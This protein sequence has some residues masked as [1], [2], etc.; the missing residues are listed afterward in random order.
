MLI[1]STKIVCPRIGSIPLPQSDVT[2]PSPI[3]P[4]RCRRTH[5]GGAQVPATSIL[6]TL[7]HSQSIDFSPLFGQ[8]Q[9]TTI[10]K[11]EKTVKDDNIVVR[12]SIPRQTQEH[13]SSGGSFKR[14]GHLV[15][16]FAI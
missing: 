11:F 1:P 3:P 14:K 6:S 10:E 4:R 2:Y 8:L 9:E 16:C 12:K 15:Y 5:L 7:F 13:Y